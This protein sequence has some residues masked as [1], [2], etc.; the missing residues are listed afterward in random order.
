[1]VCKP[2]ATLPRLR[3]RPSDSLSQRTVI[4]PSTT[5]QDQQKNGESYGYE[6]KDQENKL[7][8]GNESK[9]RSQVFGNRVPKEKRIEEEKDRSEK[10]EVGDECV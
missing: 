10:R 3:V 9:K 8:A 1:M 4:M 2:R 6:K 5:K 7:R